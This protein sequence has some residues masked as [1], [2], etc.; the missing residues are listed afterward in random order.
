MRFFRM[1]ND[2]RGLALLRLVEEDGMIRG[3]NNAIMFQE[4]NA[5]NRIILNYC[6]SFA[7]LNGFQYKSRIEGMVEIR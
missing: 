5:G 7:L 3:P 2:G 4:E 6:R 1:H